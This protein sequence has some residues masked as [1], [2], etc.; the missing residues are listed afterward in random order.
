[1]LSGDVPPGPPGEVRLG[2]WAEGSNF[3]F[4]LNGRY[5]FGVTDQ[6]Y[7][8]GTLGVFAQASGTTPITITF[9]DLVVR[10]VNAQL[11]LE[12]PGP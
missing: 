4:F 8:T 11:P 5:Q 12:T 1:M 9:S 6:N 10:Q 3:H 2:V 7:R